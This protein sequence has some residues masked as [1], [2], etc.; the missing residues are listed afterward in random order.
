M[1]AVYCESHGQYVLHIQYRKAAAVSI[2]K[3]GVFWNLQVQYY[4]FQQRVRSVILVY[5]LSHQAAELRVTSHE[6]LTVLIRK[7]SCKKGLLTYHYGHHNSLLP[8]VTLIP[9]VKISSYFVVLT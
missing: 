6:R 7:A 9:D 2:G 5:T 1:I 8:V 4:W 3:A